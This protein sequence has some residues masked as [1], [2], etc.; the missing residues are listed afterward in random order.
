MRSLIRLITATASHPLNRASLGSSMAALSRVLRWQ[1]AARLLPE[2][3]FALPFANGTSLV[4]TRG[5][6]GA[7]GNWYNGLDEPEEM[8]F[9]LHVLQPGDQFID[10]G[11]N[12]GSFSVLAASVEGVKTIAFEPVPDTFQRLARNI[13]FNQL[14]ERIDVR[15]Q[16][17]SDAPGVL[18]FTTSLDSMNYVVPD[19]APGSD[20]TVAVDVVRLDDVVS[21][22]GPGK[23]A[24]KIDVEGFEMSVL[25]GGAGLFASDAALCVIMETNGS[26]H[27]YGVKDGA[28][29]ARMR[30]YGFAP[31]HYS[32][33]SRSFSPAGEGDKDHIN[34]IFVKDMDEVIRRVRQAGAITLAGGTL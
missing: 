19:R 1:L 30:D 2:A 27:R 11:A 7:T 8:G 18:Q 23:M 33:F 13:A 34:T 21:P 12:I 3:A 9:L 20:D 4:V 26:G 22:N 17:V 29:F 32:P 16:G 5:M 25:N 15:Q 14:A 28:L 24:F 31:Y 10:I 6:V